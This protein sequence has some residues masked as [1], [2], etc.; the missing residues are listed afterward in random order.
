MKSW[1]QPYPDG[2]VKPVGFIL[3]SCVVVGG[4]GV[5]FLGVSD[6]GGWAAAAAA[7]AIAK[8]SAAALPMAAQRLR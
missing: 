7:P 1:C 4:R 3:G 8:Q 2:S 6:P 5:V